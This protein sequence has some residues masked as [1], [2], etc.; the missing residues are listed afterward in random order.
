MAEVLINYHLPFLVMALIVGYQLSLYFLYQYFGHREK[1]IELNRILLAYG[2]AFGFL[3]TAV[4]IRTF[5][6]YYIQN[7]QLRNV[8]FEL[9]HILVFSAAFFFLLIVSSDAFSEIM[10]PTITKMTLIAALIISVTFFIISDIFIG[11]ILISIAIVIAL[12]YLSV[13]HYNLLKKATGKV[14]KR[15]ILI[16]F[17]AIAIMG[18]IFAQADEFI[19]LL[20]RQYQIMFMI[21]S[22]PVYI[23]GELIIFLGVFRFPAFLEFGWRKNLIVL[24][25]INSQNSQL[26]YKFN[27]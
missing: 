6:T 24:Y 25:I 3:N 10:P 16:T 7:P 20:D 21:M 18:G 11:A 12:I 17:G 26:L 9:S 5:Y 13:F 19:L 4:L 23:I 8:F 1:S 27:F 2:T 22:S 15:L 14:R